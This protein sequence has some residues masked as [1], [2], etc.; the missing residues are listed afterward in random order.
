MTWTGPIALIVTDAVKTNANATWELIDSDSGG[1]RTFSVP[2]SPSG[3]PNPTHWGANSMLE[4]EC[5]EALRG[6]LQ[7]DGTYL[8]LTNA[9]FSAF[10]QARATKLGR[11]VPNNP[12]Q[13]RAQ[14]FMGLEYQDFDSF[15]VERGLQRVREPVDA[16]GGR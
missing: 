10:L 11:P 8:P 12:G 5:E 6:H 4:R 7:P 3:A 9:E 13:F 15:L 1:Y 14:Y 2:L 16:A